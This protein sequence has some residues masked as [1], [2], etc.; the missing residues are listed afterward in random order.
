MV[1]YIGSW[2]RGSI[3]SAENCSIRAE[4][5]YSS[6]SPSS[7]NTDSSKSQLMIDG[8]AAVH[9]VNG[10]AESHIV[11][12]SAQPTASWLDDGDCSHP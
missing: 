9:P 6:S 2:L 10:D 11:L 12:Q 8:L 1:V 4:P 5:K 3:L 7:S